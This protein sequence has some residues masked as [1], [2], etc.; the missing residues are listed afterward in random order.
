MRIIVDI[1]HF[2]KQAAQLVDA[3]AYVEQ[4]APY[5]RQMENK[6]STPWFG[7]IR[8]QKAFFA[9]CETGLAVPVHGIVLRYF[10]SEN[11]SG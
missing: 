1:N 7:K 11:V 3:Q 6:T 5:T 2:I 9:S 8:A 4:K 10:R